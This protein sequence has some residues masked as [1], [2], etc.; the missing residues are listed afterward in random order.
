MTKRAD[1]VFALLSLALHLT[2]V[3]PRLKKER[4][5]GAHRAA[6]TPSTASRAVTL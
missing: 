3:R 5:R 2:A 1:A 4:E 6:T